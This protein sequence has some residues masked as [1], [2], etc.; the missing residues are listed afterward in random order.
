[1][2]RQFRRI[3][4]KLANLDRDALLLAVRV[5]LLGAVLA[6]ALDAAVGGDTLSA[7][8]LAATHPMTVLS[9]GLLL[10]GAAG[11]ALGIRPEISAALFAAGSL[12]LARADTDT[13]LWV[14]V[15][16]GVAMVGPGK[17]SLSRPQKARRRRRV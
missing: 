10:G 3:N 1:M 13:L 17:H 15:A 8:D 6:V 7:T 16:I 4:V 2:L 14:L 5:L 12:W 9:V 11:L